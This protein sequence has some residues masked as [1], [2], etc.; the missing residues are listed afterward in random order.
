M[1]RARAI[2]VAIIGGGIGGIG[3]A[4]H[5]ARRGTRTFTV[6]EKSEGPGGTWWDNRYP[7]AECDI[8]S[9]LYSYS[10]K[11]HDWTRTHASQEEIQQYVEETIDD[12]QLR[13]HIRFGV[14]VRSAEWHERR[15]QYLVTLDNDET[16]WFDVVVSAVGMLNVPK[17]P[18]WPGI[19][20]F[21]G[22]LFHSARWDPKAELDGKRVAV[23]GAGA[24]ATQVVPG[25]QPRVA[26]L[27]SFQREP[28]WV[29]PKGD[30]DLTPE[31]RKE[32]RRFGW[33]RKTRFDM[34][35][36]M[37]K[38][39]G[40]DPE[41]IEAQRKRLTARI[42]EA[43]DDRPDLAEAMTPTF[44]PRCK[45]NVFSDIYYPALKQDNVRLVPRG[46][47]RITPRGV[48]DSTGEEH[49]VDAVVLTTGFRAA[50]FLTTVKV[51]GRGGTDLHDQWG[52]DPEAF[53]GISVP[54]FPNFYM[55]YG[56]N[57]HGTVVSFVLE[58][59][60]EYVAKDV[61]RLRKRGGGTLEVRPEA[62]A[63]FQR[64]LQEAISKVE[65]WKS[66][67]NNFYTSASGK[68][69]VQWPWTHQR[70]Y[71]WTVLARRFASI[72]RPATAETRAA[73]TAI[74]PL[75]QQEEAA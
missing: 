70:Y 31:E 41:M 51:T 30:R 29:L 56:P 54:N 26:E 43:F 73:R 68:N 45:R 65:T 10:F 49:E 16:H 66:G 27:L 7:G 14:G 42:N 39:H 1:S 59:Q 24:S 28:T 34:I 71:A 67:C 4:V 48:V 37:D 57:T 19:E 60:A 63:W 15:Q 25:L 6:F 36:A 46:V 13:E 72:H 12:Y 35:R 58:R 33:A 38:G 20:T 50:E 62:N 3:A 55:L 2:E 18:D 22:P 9:A 75:P 61:R 23:V 21:E 8:P 32:R 52:L 17:V 11:P 47:E 40:S 74:V 64:V 44:Q 5:L 53:L 69:V